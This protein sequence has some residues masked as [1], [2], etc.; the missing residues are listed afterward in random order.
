MPAD[1]RENVDAGEM[2]WLFRVVFDS[3]QGVKRTLEMEV[4]LR[5]SHW[6]PILCPYKN[7][8]R[9]EQL[10]LFAVD[11]LC[12]TC[13][14]CFSIRKM[15]GEDALE[16]SSKNLALIVHLEATALPRCLQVQLRPLL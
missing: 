8:V 1:P 12:S 15:P 9:S 7:E 2:I 3:V 14:R 4:H 6:Q 10:R 13:S 16:D 11:H 5:Q